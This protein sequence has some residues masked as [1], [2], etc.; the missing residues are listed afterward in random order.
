MEKITHIKLKQYA[1]SGANFANV[2]WVRGLGVLT[3]LCPCE[4]YIVTLRTSLNS[5][6]PPL[7]HGSGVHG[8]T[9][10]V[11][12]IGGQLWGVEFRLSGLLAALSIREAPNSYLSSI[13]CCARGSLCP[14]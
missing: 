1:E 6:F 3:W 13:F 14:I 2:L 9:E 4:Q 10:G 7:R 11:G 8:A 5:G 12:V